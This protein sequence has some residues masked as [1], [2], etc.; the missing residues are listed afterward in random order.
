MKKSGL[1]ATLALSGALC[2]AT[3]P[4]PAFAASYSDVESNAWYTAGGYID[5]VSTNGY[6]TGY[7]GTGLFG[8]DDTLTRA[9]AATALYRAVNGGFDDPSSYL[10]ENLTSFTDVETG[11]YYINAVTWLYENGIITGYDGGT[12]FAP[13]SPITREELVMMMSRVTSCLYPTG[14]TDSNGASLT[15][16]DDA[17]DISSWA[18]N[19]MAWSVDI[20]IV[21]G[22]EVDFL[23][24]DTPEFSSTIIEP[25]R[26][27]TRAEE[28]KMLTVFRRDYVDKYDLK[29][30]FDW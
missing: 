3:L 1:T 17:T 27:A 4:A 30:C 2:L 5:Y 10:D 28:A 29:L 23:A 22:Q 21:S 6:M 18:T 16:F 12:T 24:S 14:T 15:K 26:N 13:D 25:T 19:A 9:E 11:T 20:G 7:S 8:P